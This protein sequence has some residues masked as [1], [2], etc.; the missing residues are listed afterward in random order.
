[1]VRVLRGATGAS[2]PADGPA[3]APAVIDGDVVTG[4]PPAA[5]AADPAALFMAVACAGPSPS[6]QSGYAAWKSSSE[7]TPQPQWCRWCRRDGVTFLRM[8]TTLKGKKKWMK[9]K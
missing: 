8:R 1:M 3:A 4:A 7:A 6:P 9:K 5:A 2:K